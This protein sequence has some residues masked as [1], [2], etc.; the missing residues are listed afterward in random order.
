M[1][2][3]DD[4]RVVNTLKHIIKTDVVEEDKLRK[5]KRKKIYGRI[6]LS[7]LISGNK[8]C[9]CTWANT[10]KISARMLPAH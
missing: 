8:K 1:G 2:P 6:V 5:S 3:G 9:V 4:S 10:V 7:G